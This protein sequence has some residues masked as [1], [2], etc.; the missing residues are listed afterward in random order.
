MVW[1]DFPLELR[2][3]F[4]LLFLEFR[5][6]LQMSFVGFNLQAHWSCSKPQTVGDLLGGK[7]HILVDRIATKL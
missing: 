2:V 7:A 5:L 3:N 6:Q 1:A 4:K